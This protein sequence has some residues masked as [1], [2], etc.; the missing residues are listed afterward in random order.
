MRSPTLFRLERPPHRS[1]GQ[2]D[3]LSF[4]DYRCLYC[5]NRLLVQFHDYAPLRKEPGKKEREAETEGDLPPIHIVCLTGSP[6]LYPLVGNREMSLGNLAVYTC[7][8]VPGYQFPSGQSQTIK[9]EKKKTNKFTVI[10]VISQVFSSPQS[11]CYCLHFR[12][13][14]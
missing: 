11:A 1:S 12:V 5:H 13:L 2:R 8:S 10:L 7:N 3:A 9:K 4:R 14:M 6:F